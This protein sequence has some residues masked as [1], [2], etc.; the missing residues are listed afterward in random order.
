VNT[1]GLGTLHSLA[2]TNNASVGGE[3][4][5]TGGKIVNLLNPT[6][7]QDAASKAYVDAQ[8]AA[9]TGYTETDPQVGTI[10]T[11][12]KICQSDGSSIN[13]DIDSSSLGG[14]NLGNHTATQALA[15]GTYKITDM[16]DPTT[17]QDAATKAY[18]DTTLITAAD[19]LGSHVAAQ[20]L[21]M[22]GFDIVN[23]GAIS[24]TQVS[25]SGEVSAS[26]ITSAGVVKV[27]TQTACAPSD[28]GA[29]RY[30]GGS[31]AFEYCD[32]GGTWL[33][34]KKPQCQDD[35]TGECTLSVLRASDDPDLDPENIRCGENVLG[36]IGTHGEASVAAFSLTDQTGVALSTLITSNILQVSGIPAGCNSEVVA[37]GAGNPQFQVCSNAT[38]ST[39]IQDWTNVPHV[40]SNGQYFRVRLTSAATGGTDYTAL[41]EL[42]ATRDNWTV[43]TAGIDTTPNAFTFTDETGQALNALN[44]S[45]IITIS[46]INAPTSVTVTGTGS[47]QISI[48]GGAWATSGTITNGQTL[49][50]RLTTANAFTTTRSATVNVGGVTD[51]WS[52]TTRAAANCTNKTISWSNCDAASGSMTHTQSKTITNTTARYVGTRNITCTDGVI[53]QSG[54]SCAQNTKTYNVNTSTACINGFCEC[55]KA[56]QLYVEDPA[57]ATNVCVNRKNCLGM[58]SFVTS[59]GVAHQTHCNSN[60]G[61]CYVNGHPGNLKCTSVTC[62]GCP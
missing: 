45:N 28:E 7:A 15:M 43:T 12:G 48:N 50:V 14:D 40:I 13:C 53:S 35:D 27:G 31:P 55:V 58:D 57:K 3:L 30:S 25:S 29:I 2:V 17:A 26:Q 10:A 9:G 41:V 38:C 34:F 42:G 1:S 47:P 21:D 32:G 37:T 24:A 49:Q 39:L 54:G 8:V 22:A 4:D 33:P 23:A 60:G 36:V 19:N 62:T 5:L 6:A 61:G 52:V 18:V 11:S 51:V 56:G 59:H 46:G 44:T 16:A 20:N